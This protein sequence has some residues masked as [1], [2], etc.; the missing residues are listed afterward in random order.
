MHQSTAA[1]GLRASGR[2]AIPRGVAAFV[3]APRTLLALAATAFLLGDLAMLAVAL[4]GDFGFDFAISYQQAGHRLL[5]GGDLYA[6]SPTYEFRYSP[7]AAAAFTVLAPL[8]PAVAAVAWLVAK[9]AVLGGI[10]FAFARPWPRESRWLVAAAVVLFPPALHDLVIGNVSILTL[11]VM[12]ALARRWP[13]APVLFG[14]LLLL[15]PKP[16]LL[17]VAAWLLVVR[18]REAWTAAGVITGGALLGVLVFGVDPWVGYLSSFR[19]PLGREFTANIGLSGLLGPAGVAAGVVCAAI[20]LALA[21]R[22]GR[23]GLGLAIISG[24]LLGPYTFIHYLTPVLMAAE[25]PLRRRPRVLAPFPVLM[26]VFPLMPVWLLLLAAVSYAADPG[27]RPGRQ[28]RGEQ[29]REIDE[30]DWR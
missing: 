23:D 28:R 27:R 6:W 2:P 10:A 17:P 20:V 15:A 25:P 13:G 1:R 11:A 18:P 5:E 24:V 9:L 19:E 8:H 26:L 21:L 22:R 29:E 7:W 16:H 4:N 14:L 30:Q 12:L 3:T